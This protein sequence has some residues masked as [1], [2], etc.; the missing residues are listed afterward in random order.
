LPT[1]TSCGV[2][3]N[4]LLHHP[5]VVGNDDDEEEDDDGGEGVDCEVDITRIQRN[6]NHG[7]R[8]ISAVALF[9]LRASPPG[10]APITTFWT[11]HVTIIITAPLPSGSVLFLERAPRAK[12]RLLTIM[13]LLVVTMM[14][15]LLLLLRILLLQ[16]LLLSILL[17]NLTFGLS[18]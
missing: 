16:L 6:N 7:R 13:T 5:I 12:L 1:T 8:R 18:L 11:V 2:L 10:E 3:H 4:Q 14:T 17:K 15:M 9:V